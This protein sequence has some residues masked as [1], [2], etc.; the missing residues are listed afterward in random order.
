MIK[1]DGKIL[2]L[3]KQIDIKRQKLKEIEK[4]SP[5]TNLSLEFNSVRININTLNKA[6]IIELMVKLNAELLSSK[7][8]GIEGNYM[9]SGF[10]LMDWI[11]DLRA[12]LTQLSKREE[13]NKLKQMESKLDQLLS[14]EKKTE[15]ELDEIAELLK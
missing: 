4:F 1:N 12:K 3:K 11:T 9:I 13:E 6:K 7:D 8:L 5:V 14:D 10:T 15:L 2:E